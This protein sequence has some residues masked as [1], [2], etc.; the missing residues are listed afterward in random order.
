VK[1]SGAVLS[2][3]S[4]PFVEKFSHSLGARAASESIL[5][6]V[7]A[8]D[9]STGW[10]EGLPRTY[11]TGEDFESCAT[12]AR[13]VLWPRIRERELAATDFAG[14]LREI[15][16]LLPAH[17]SG[18]AIAHNAVRCA[19]ELALIDAWLRGR[20]RGLGEELPRARDEVAYSAVIP[21]GSVESTTSHAKQYRM[22]GFEQ[23]KVKIDGKDDVARLQAVRAVFGAEASLRVDGN[24]AYT[25]EGAL[26]A[27][28]AA[29]AAGVR[30][31][32][33]EQMLARGALPEWADLTARSPVPIMVDESLVTEEDARALIAAKACHVFNI[34][35]S[36]CGGL[37]PTLRIVELARAAG[38]RFQLG[39]HVG[40]SAILSAVGRHLACHLADLW[41]IE[42]SF[43]TLLLKEDVAR[44]TVRFGH[45]GRAKFI[46]GAGIGVEV[47]P[48]VVE[49][50]A[51]RSLKL[52]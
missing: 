15:G 3:V 45:R 6:S 16:E 28:A 30:L 12:H 22:L 4:L 35:I 8:A 11:V 44:E 39:C 47:R 13:D 5:V 50:Y 29:G 20:G 31:D 49:R 14:L 17:G 43:G 26:A 46:A 19:F 27:L 48:D 25:V 37:G 40:E 52:D 7:T 41:F 33:A 51:V 21:T 23:V 36:K 42:G 32:S 1:A 10:G 34:R 2:C 24:A 18:G 38:I 9:G